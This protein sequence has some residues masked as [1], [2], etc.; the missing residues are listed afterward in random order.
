MLL[1]RIYLHYRICS[2]EVRQ[3]RN[4]LLENTTA[5]IH[6]L[7]LLQD[8]H[9]HTFMYHSRWKCVQT[10]RTIF[11]HSLQQQMLFGTG[12]KINEKQHK[13]TVRRPECEIQLLWIFG[14]RFIYMFRF[15]F[16]DAMRH[17]SEV[18]SLKLV[19]ICAFEFLLWSQFIKI[20]F[21]YFYR[22]L[23]VAGCWMTQKDYMCL[24]LM[25]IHANEISASWT[26]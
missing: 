23:L 16:S 12:R 11:A 19:A 14:R 3:K 17:R 9:I 15:I 25:F 4:E 8:N 20:L 2:T 26:I 22:W 1:T 21:I 7:Q 10:H 18:R 24:C 5:H 6:G 13:T